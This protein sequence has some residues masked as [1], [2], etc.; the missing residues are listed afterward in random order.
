MADRTNSIQLGC[1]L[2]IDPYEHIAVGI[3]KRGSGV[4]TL[5]KDILAKTEHLYKRQIRCKTPEHLIETLDKFDKELKG[6]SKTL[7]SMLTLEYSDA[8][9]KLDETHY[10]QLDNLFV[11]G[12]HYK[13][14]IVWECQP[15][16]FPSQA[17]NSPQLLFA[18]SGEES[19]SKLINH[20]RSRCYTDRV[21]PVINKAIAATEDEPIKWFMIEDKYK[22]NLSY[23]KKR[24]Y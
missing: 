5:I 24:T 20:W 10:K 16:G 9:T 8:Y 15:G 4:T 3:T 17:Y 18:C 23:T 2:I 14:V 11:N 22:I 6:S 1:G 12:R 21:M 13:C 19:L 7:D